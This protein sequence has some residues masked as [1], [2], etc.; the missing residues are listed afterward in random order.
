MDLSSLAFKFQ[1]RRSISKHDTTSSAWCPLNG[2]GWDADTIT[3][4]WRARGLGLEL[5]S[6]LE[7]E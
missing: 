7:D 4:R 3:N 1:R 6:A 5:G 2:Q